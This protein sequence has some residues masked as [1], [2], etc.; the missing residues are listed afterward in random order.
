MKKQ[1]IMN[2]KKYVAGVDFGSSNLVMAV[3]SVDAKSGLINVEALLS[4]PTGDNIEMGVIQ[5]VN[6]VC[7]VLRGM[8][9]ELEREL[10]ISI[11]EAYA[12]VSGAFIHYL[13]YS[14]HVFVT[15]GGVVAQSDVDA[16]N[17][18]MSRVT[19]PDDEDVMERFP[20][21][22]IVDHR[23]ETANPVGAFSRQL[24]STFAFIVGKREPLG[25]L[26]MVFDECGLSLA[27]IF[28]NSAIVADAVLNQEEKSDGAAVI[29]LG[30]DT[31][32]VAVC[33][34]G[35]VR[36]AA[37]IPMGGRA[38]DSDINKHGVGMRNTEELKKQFG[39]AIAEN[40]PA[41]AGISIKT[42]GKTSK[43]IMK[44]NLASI[45][46]AR[47]MDIIDYVKTEL[48]DSGYDDKL[49]YGLVLTG[50]TSLI[51]EIDTLFA[52]H[53]ERD[54]RLTL[55]TEGIDAV[56]GDKIDSPEYTAAVALLIAGA[57]KGACSIEETEA[58]FED[59]E[60]V[61]FDV[62]DESEKPAVRKPFDPNRPSTS[63]V[64][65]PPTREIKPPVPPKSRPVTP[66]PPAEP[67]QT[68]AT[69]AE[70][71]PG[72]EPVQ[73]V[74]PVEEPAVDPVEEPKPKPADD[75]KRSKRGIFGRLSEMFTDVL[76]GGDSFS[77]TSLNASTDGTPAKGKSV[78]DTLKSK[79]GM[80]LEGFFVD[81]DD[82][83]EV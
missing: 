55:A 44:R 33:S 61:S 54:V 7:T 29:D 76:G 57:K 50:G 62:G 13:T 82:R 10:G 18:R 77:D 75:D 11:H 28:A 63:T 38:I 26:K 5:N 3:G 71:T 58:T 20:L 16:L 22:Y 69:V 51:P 19:V 24:S 48:K 45:I 65:V 72:P 43:T 2:N 66:T 14:D 68:S 31:T 47:L 41:T 1:D 32:D 49:P 39:T 23:R 27:G 67:V 83:D 4:R 9:S 73:P 6:N 12:G 40:V 53:T 81:G 37:T 15:N 46:E 56:S 52:R 35:L 60:E 30:G 79:K 17:D 42:A 8:K 36:Y 25:R 59:E 64:Y 74:Q 21:N 70:T 34:G 78:H 80:N